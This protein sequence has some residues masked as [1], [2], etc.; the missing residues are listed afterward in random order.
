MGSAAAVGTFLRRRVV[1]GLSFASVS[2]F[3]MNSA[4]DMPNAGANLKMV[5]MLAL[6]LPSSSKDR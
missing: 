1:A 6:F 3:A 2:T 4:T 5:L